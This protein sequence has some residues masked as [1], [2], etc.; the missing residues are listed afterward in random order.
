MKLMFPAIAAVVFSTVLARADTVTSPSAVDV[1]SPEA[2][3][4]TQIPT[5]SPDAVAAP[6]VQP[7]AGEVP[8][9][10]LTVEPVEIA[11]ASTRTLDAMVPAPMEAAAP[12][13]GDDYT[14]KLD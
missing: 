6:L 11:P 9:E 7:Q 4:S 5:A 8:V 10:V 3:V 1:F 14:F 13:V 2:P 12:Q